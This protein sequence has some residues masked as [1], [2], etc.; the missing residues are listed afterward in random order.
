VE[1]KRRLQSIPDD[2]LLHRLA[3][4]I[5][6]SRRVEA[7]IVAHIAEV[8]ERR[9]YAREAFPSMFAYC[10]EV[11]HLS[12]AEAYLRISAA[13]ASRE[14]PML[15]TLLADGRLHLTAIAKLAPH[16]TRENRDGLLERATHRSKRQIE[17]QIAEIAPRPDVPAVVRRLPE[18]STLPA[19]GL[20]VA[21]NRGEGSMLELRPDA[22]AA[23]E[24]DP[25]RAL[26][27]DG[28]GA[29]EQGPV[30]ELGPDAVVA[31]ETEA[32]A[33]QDK[34]AVSHGAL[35]THFA[36]VA[37]HATA[38]AATASPVS[39]SVVQPLSP[40]RY[41]VQFTASAEFHHKLERLRALMGSR[42]PDGDL[43]AVIEQAVTEKLER[44]EARRFAQTKAPRKGPAK[45]ETEP[46]ISPA[47]RHSPPETDPSPS[48]R[49]IPAAVR[50][51]VR[52]RDGGR[53][54][55]V[56]EQGRRCKERD[57]LEFRHRHPFGLGGDHSVANV[58]LMC[59]AHNAYMAEYDY[60]REAMA[61]HRRPHSRA[62]P[63]PAG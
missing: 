26:G 33:G 25:V 56:D 20:L 62:S 36:A 51:A 38:V 3:E 18:R 14:H 43:A 29:P 1:K 48:S 61:S 59:R 50:R 7:D 11:L 39:R 19:A 12:E 32:E 35:H 44:L 23:P 53:C 54:R 41:K 9:L 58:G 15:L 34:A 10:M 13:R 30:L 16:L 45:T 42:V 49:H 31:S 5:G 40:G 24:Q 63:A 2:E 27:P 47:P 46:G 57:R 6:Q 37:A 4:L 8:D 60:G 55:Y 28:V 17:K 52:E 21:P 22:V